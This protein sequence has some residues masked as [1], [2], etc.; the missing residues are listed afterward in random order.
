MNTQNFGF[1][2][3][4]QLLFCAKMAGVDTTAIGGFDKA[5]LDNIKSGHKKRGR[6]V[7]RLCW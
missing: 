2:A 1:I 7:T 6:G 4:G 3:L 5:V